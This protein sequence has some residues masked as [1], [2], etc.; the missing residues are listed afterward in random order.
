MRPGRGKHLLHQSFAKFHGRHGVL[1][2]G[3]VE[4]QINARVVHVQLKTK[5]C[6]C[7]LTTPKGPLPLQ[8]E[9]QP[10][11]YKEFFMSPKELTEN[12]I[13]EGK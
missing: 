2:L 8:K 5:S 13:W 10:P 11:E 12:K 9:Y 7:P 1:S 3:A 4:V 6:S